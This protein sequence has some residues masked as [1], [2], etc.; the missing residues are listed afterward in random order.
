[1]RMWRINMICVTRTMI[2]RIN[3]L[4]FGGAALVPWAAADEECGAR[5]TPETIA[6]LEAQERAG[7]YVL[8][9]APRYLLQVRLAAHIV[10]RSNGTGGLSANALAQTIA[11]TNAFWA[12]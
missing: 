10:R 2:A 1:M 12:P 5:L 4:L 3:A 9:A 6:A 11:T 7:A 8:R